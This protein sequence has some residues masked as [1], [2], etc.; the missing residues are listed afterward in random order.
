MQ[1]FHEA[2]L[3]KSETVSRVEKYGRV[4]EW[5]KAVLLKST[6][7]KRYRE[8]ESHSFLFLRGFLNASK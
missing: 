6:V 7:P 4:A 8:F 1:L 2:P 5:F 3:D